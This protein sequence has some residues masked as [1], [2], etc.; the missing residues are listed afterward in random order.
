MQ[1]VNLPF[2]FTVTQI[3]VL[4]PTGCEHCDTGYELQNS[5]A[6]CAHKNYMTAL[7]LLYMPATAQAHECCQPCQPGWY[8]P[9]R[10]SPKLCFPKFNA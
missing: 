10:G 2:D 9:P 4:L 6:E 1:T 7:G 5:K 3:T 8:K